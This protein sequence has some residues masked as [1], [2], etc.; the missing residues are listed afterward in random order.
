MALDG[1]LW[2]SFSADPRADG[3]LRASDADRSA[4]F[5]ILNDALAQG[6]IDLDEHGERLD[7]AAG[8]RE[9]GEV[10]PLIE[11]LVRAPET[12]PGSTLAVRPELAALDEY[13]GTPTTPEAIDAAAL[14]LYR[15][16]LRTA[17]A[18]A[19]T[20]SLITVLIWAITSIAAG[21][22]IFFWPLFVI[23]GTGIGVVTTLSSKQSIIRRKRQMLTVRARAKLGDPR[24]QAEIEAN[25]R[26]F[27][28]RPESSRDARRERRREIRRRT[29]ES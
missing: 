4:V 9:L 2:S 8:I 25:P 1:S 13:E 5:E 27:R 14:E 23:L 7:S 21:S 12:L 19:A 22:L 11:D 29:G 26:V 18:G 3:R 17:L 28:Y 16:D 6:L 15:S 24:A 20:P 10:V